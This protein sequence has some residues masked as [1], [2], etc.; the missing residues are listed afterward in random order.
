[1]STNKKGFKSKTLKTPV[2]TGGEYR[3]RTGDLLPARIKFLEENTN[4]QIKKSTLKARCQNKKQLHFHVTA[5][6]Y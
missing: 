1:M 3:I 2:F 4:N 6:F 5:R